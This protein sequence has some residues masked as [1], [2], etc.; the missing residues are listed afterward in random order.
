[1]ITVVV[2]NHSCSFG[3]AFK[4]VHKKKR[5]KEEEKKIIQS[6]LFS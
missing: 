6:H 3:I 4:C 1:M 2:S 5:E